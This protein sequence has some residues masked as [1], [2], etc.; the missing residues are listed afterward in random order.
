M[1]DNKTLYVIDLN[2]QFSPKISRAD[3][4][5]K[6]FDK[7]VKQSTSK[8]GGL[9]SMAA[10]MSPATLGVGAIVAGVGVL[11]KKLIG[12]GS[13]MESIRTSFSVMFGSTEKGNKM[14]DMMNEFANVT[15]FTNDQVI[16]AGK[17][18]KAFAFEAET[19]APTMKI[20]GDVAAGTGSD[21]SEMARIFGKIK[22]NGRL[23]G[24]EL[25]M[26]IDRGFNPLNHMSE[27]TG[28]SIAELRKEMSKGQ[29]SFTMVQDAFV[30]A[31][32]EGGQFNDMMKKQ[33]ETF[34]GMMSTIQ[35]KFGMLF[36][37]GGEGLTNVLKPILKWVISFVDMLATIDFSPLLSGMS[38]WW[39]NLK[40]VLSPL[41]DLVDLLFSG[42]DSGNTFQKVINGISMAMRAT[43]VPV[44]IS[45][46][47]FKDLFTLLSSGGNIMKAMG[48]FV[49][50]DFVGAYE[51]MKKGSGQFKKV[52]SATSAAIA[53]EI[54]AFKD[55]WNTSRDT[56]PGVD[57]SG[58]H[59]TGATAGGGAGGNTPGTSGGKRKTTSGG[60]AGVSSGGI[61]NVQLNIEKLIENLNFNSV[62]NQSTEALKQ[63]ITRVLVEA[64]SD[65]TRLI[66]A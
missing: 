18:L 25:D 29:I 33:S 4:N 2:D 59:L 28:K 13:E 20:L 38:L 12:L 23:M 30:A 50:G 42:S 34:G 24:A 40:Q 19:I 52:G 1:S 37:Q 65:A 32:S 22:G 41:G 49:S 45:I 60:V 57:I 8:S 35:G 16:K 21:F 15:P 26:L 14:L 55:L 44:K 43:F 58:G 27:V 36:T 47:L 51:S 64:A 61:K 5:F 39:E 3:K 48:Q 62:T 66:G 10:M 46:A 56:S 17:T 53:G 6:G 11:G 7:N 9:G 63:Q 31:T 54:Q